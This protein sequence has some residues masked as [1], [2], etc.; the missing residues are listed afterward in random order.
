[1]TNTLERT[2]GHGRPGAAPR[3]VQAR[4]VDKRCACLYAGV[5]S[6]GGVV[7]ARWTNGS[8]PLFLTPNLGRRRSHDISC[9]DRLRLPVHQQQRRATLLDDPGDSGCECLFAVAPGSIVTR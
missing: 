4:M 3:S 5:K 9:L 1:M 8:V 7:V 2:P 6:C